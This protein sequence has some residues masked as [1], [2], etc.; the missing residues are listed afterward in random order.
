MTTDTVLRIARIFADLGDAVF[1]QG[2]AVLIHGE[3]TEDQ[4]PNALRRVAEALSRAARL[5][6]RAGD[7]DTAE[8]LA[9]AARE[10]EQAY[11][12]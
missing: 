12:G 5:A 4:N 9:E 8:D 7:D 11:H 10:I 2:E 3:P 1:E 6:A